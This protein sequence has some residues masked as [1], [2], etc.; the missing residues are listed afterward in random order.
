MLTQCVDT[1]VGTSGNDTFDGNEV[2]L[3]AGG[4]AA[5]FTAL[6]SLDGGAGTDTLII[7]DTT[8]TLALPPSATVKNIENAQITGTGTV[9]GDVSAWTG[10]T[11]LTVKNL[12]GQ[13]T[14]ISAAATTAVTLTDSALA[15]GGIIVDGGS[16][17]TI[18]SSTKVTAGTID[19]GG[20]TAAA[21]DVVVTS[22]VTGTGISGP[23]ITVTGGQTVSVTQNLTNTKVNT[24][25]IAGKVDVIGD[26]N[27][28]TVTATEAV[29]KGAKVA[30]IVNAA[31]TVTD[32]S[33]SSTDAGTITNVSVSGYT[34]LSIDASSVTDLSL[35]NGSSDVTIDNS[36]AVKAPVETLNVTV[37]GDSTLANI[38]SK[39]VTDLNV[40][41]AALLT[42]TSAA[43]LAGLTDVTVTGSAGLVADLTGSAIEVVNLSGTSGD[44]TITLDARTADLAVTGGSGS[45]SITTV[46]ALDAGAVIDLGNG[47]DLY[48]FDTAA[49]KGSVVKGGLGNDTIAVDDGALL[50]AA[51]AA[52][53]SGFETLEIAG[54][55][56]TYDM[57]I[58]GLT[59]TKLAGNVAIT[60]A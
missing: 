57:S 53:Y 40:A 52:V 22:N 12:G 9:D 50:N 21:G 55:T 47:D 38:T 16:D 20:T 28:T 13:A 2:A 4:L 14:G 46:G 49:A 35:A 41:G 54:G 43:G 3:S 42:L 31:V 27:T 26:A 18:T 51:A 7:S 17:V 39:N 19:V 15:G 59:D 10:L 24:D 11:S 5:S 36:D 32:A 6:D 25:V 45:D 29:A 1:K 44:N 8:G 34:T 56:G 60:N 30:G 33:F 23:A 48:D 58:L 37:N